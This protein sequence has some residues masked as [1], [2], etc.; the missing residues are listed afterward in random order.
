M[1]HEELL[2]WRQLVICT[3]ADSLRVDS[4]QSDI[5]LKTIWR[6]AELDP[7]RIAHM[8]V[9]LPPQNDRHMRALETVFR[10]K[11]KDVCSPGETLHVDSMVYRTALVNYLQASGDSEKAESFMP[12]LD[13]T[14]SY[15]D[16]VLA[17][18]FFMEVE[19]SDRAEKSIHY[20]MAALRRSQSL[21]GG[22]SQ[23]FEMPITWTQTPNDPMV[24]RHEL[25]LLDLVFA[26]ARRTQNARA[27]NLRAAIIGWPTASSAH[28][29]NTR[30]VTT[31]SEP[32]SP[33]DAGLA[34]DF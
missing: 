25:A 19:R 13:D 10:A 26:G 23:T 8:V 6:L 24:K 29:S 15:R 28:P 18:Q 3:L 2:L 11:H 5:R 9:D 1:E 30:E 31:A 34:D 20:M 22:S 32:A 16:L 33:T 4:G 21:A 17:M 12:R 27:A 7:L 14:L